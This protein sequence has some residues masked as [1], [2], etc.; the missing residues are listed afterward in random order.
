MRSTE[1]RSFA[2]PGS[3]MIW[4]PV[5]IFA[6]LAGTPQPSVKTNS[7]TTGARATQ[8]TPKPAS[9]AASRESEDA[10]AEKHMLVMIN[11]SRAEAGLAALRLEASLTEAARAHALLMIANGQL[12]HQFTGEP[13]LLERIAKV[14]TLELDR[15]G[16]NIA[17]E[18]CIEHAHD[19][20][21]H[22]PPHRRN[23]L[24]EG[25]N[26]V[27]LAAMWSKGRLYVVEDFGHKVRSHSP[28]ETRQLVGTAVREV[29]R[30]AGL[31]PL[32]PYDSPTLDEAVCK[33]T[34]AGRPSARL[35]QT[36]YDNRR[37]ITY[38]QSQP[39]ILPQKALPVLRE[40]DVRQFAVGS[41]YART[42]SYPT[43]MYW[44]AILLY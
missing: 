12:E 44:V 1:K 43:G 17:H 29:R 8:P 41:C 20:L 16:E 32:V 14:S 2:S 40:P 6:L 4:A 9:V 24:D 11:H 38:T 34:E 39:E 21:M 33:M 27:G 42:P 31:E 15:A 7:T 10:A 22:S 37:I 28:A 36:A 30:Q 26:V 18:G 23:L 13:A 5:A 3:Q 25:F 19:A 35:L